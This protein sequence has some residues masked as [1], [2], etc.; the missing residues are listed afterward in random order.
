MSLPATFKIEEKELESDYTELKEAETRLRILSDFITGNSYWTGD[1]RKN[2][3]R[4]P[5]RKRD[6]ETIDLSEL[7]FGKYG[8]DKVN[9]F[10]AAVVWNYQTNKIELFETDKFSIISDIWGL[11]QD[12]D[13][14]DTKR[15]DISIKKTGTGKETRYKVDPKPAK[16]VIPEI[17]AACKSKYINLQALFGN[18]NP[19]KQPDSESVANDALNA[20][21]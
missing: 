5:V 18:G 9:T 4:V 17:L 3:K 8:A 6:N 15:Y 11:E 14:G 2:E 19:F 7:G 13:W 12:P 21:K 10:I 1:V 20:L 16:P